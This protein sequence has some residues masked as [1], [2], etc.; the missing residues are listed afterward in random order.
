MSCIE[1]VRCNDEGRRADLVTAGPPLNGIAGVEVV[2]KPP[3]DPLVQRV[4]AVFFFHGVPAGLDNAHLDR[5]EISG[6]VRTLGTAIRFVDAQTTAGHV[7]LTV[8]R[9][10]DFSDYVL[11]ITHPDLDPFYNCRRF[12]FKVDCDNPFDCQPLPPPPAA[13]PPAP[14]IDYLAKD[15]KSFRRALLDFLPTRVPGFDETN[16]ADLA[17]TIAELFASVGDR[18]SYWQ[19]AV[20]NEAYLETARQ[21]TSVKRHA[22]L[23]DYRMHDGLAA[24]TVLHFH[25]TAP[26]TVAAGAAIATNDPEPEPP[27]F[28]TEEAVACVEEQN[29]MP[30]YGWRNARCC[31]PV[32]SVAADLLGRFTTLQPGQLLLLEEVLGPVRTSDGSVILASGGA[33]PAKRQ[34]VRL[35]RIEFTTD[36]LQPPGQQEVTRVHW[37][38][39]D[40]LRVELCVAANAAGDPATVARGNLARAS[41]GRTV[42]NETVNRSTLRLA[43]GPLTFL[44]PVS[45]PAG[46]LTWLVPPDTADPRQARSSVRLTIDGET[47]NEQESLLD[48]HA[49]SPDFVVDTDRDGY[50]TLR[51]GDGELGRTPPHTAAIVATYRVG[52]GP[53]GNVGADALTVAAKPLPAGVAKVRNPLPATGGTAPEAIVDV[54]RDAPQ[55]FRRVQYRA[56]TRADY[57]DAVRRVRGVSNAFAQFRWTGSWMTVFDAIDA[58]GREG[59]SPALAAAVVARLQSQRQAGYDL[60]VNPPQ[61]VPLEIALSVC[62]R[63]EYFR[64]DV[65]RAIYDA[66]ASGPRADGTRGFFDPDSFTFGQS[67]AL[68]RLYAAVQQLPGVRAVE[69]TTFKRLNRPDYGELAAGVITLAPFEIVRLDNNPSQPDNGI[70]T[71]EGTGGK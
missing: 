52:N 5:F 57:A 38:E 7:Q 32:G 16:E 64:A 54:R 53:L 43:Q 4:L 15:Y 9:S 2:S 28:E 67:L 47:W 68:S 21:R 42:E 1:A 50:G 31:L 62:V 41:Q 70:L 71:V 60:E 40:A 17:V 20:A 22:R 3:G 66:L 26:T 48:S 35:T 30:L 11:K 51:F 14:P 18:L 24:R 8:D 36:H 23:V 58:A 46:P 10:G 56:V 13:S 39:A 33:D 37:Q 45:P 63:P 19:D 25:V 34:I 65:V 59:L 6:G 29:G 27:T 12:T 49:E 61:Y 44:H 69:A 55:E